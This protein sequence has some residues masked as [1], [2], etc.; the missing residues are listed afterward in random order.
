MPHA[1]EQADLVGHDGGHEAGQQGVVA[2][3][4]ECQHLEPENGAGHGRAEHR[5]EPGADAGHQQDAAIFGA[6]L[7]EVRELVSQRA[8]HLHRRALAPHRGAEQVR[9]DGTDQNQWR[10]AQRHDPLGVVHL[11]KQ[12]VVAGLDTLADLQVDPADGKPGQGEQTDQPTMLFARLGGPIQ[13]EQKPG[14][15]GAG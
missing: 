3:A 14:R 6:E 2:H 15:A 7:E 5:G 9:D 11:V 12:Q 1:P 4:A 10:H 8:A 13:R